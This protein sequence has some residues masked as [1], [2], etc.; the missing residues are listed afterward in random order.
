M[1]GAKITRHEYIWYPCQHHHHH[2]HRND[3]HHHHHHHHHHRN[4]HL[5]ITI[6]IT[7]TATF[8]II[9]IIIILIIMDA[10]IVGLLAEI[11]PCKS[12]QPELRVHYQLHND[13][14]D[15]DD[16]DIMRCTRLH[17]NIYYITQIPK[18]NICSTSEAQST[19]WKIEKRSQTKITRKQQTEKPW[20]SLKTISK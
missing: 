13:D 2:H 9:V 14:D 17:Q 15:D 20:S 12:Y 4:H 18:L 8:T 1:R 10:Y 6:T 3:H 11:A 5:V 7:I 19:W 16:D